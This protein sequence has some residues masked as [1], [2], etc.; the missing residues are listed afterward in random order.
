[1]QKPLSNRIESGDSRA[2]VFEASLFLPHAQLSFRAEILR[3]NKIYKRTVCG[4]LEGI[5]TL[6]STENKIRC[7]SAYPYAM[8]ILRCKIKKYF[9]LVFSFNML[10]ISMPIRRLKDSI[11]LITKFHSEVVII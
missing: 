5:S 9:L 8:V 3:L 6:K 10:Y 11:F 1:M 2:K 4:R 7:N